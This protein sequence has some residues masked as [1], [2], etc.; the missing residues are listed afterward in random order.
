MGV[1]M[2]GQSNTLEEAIKR[3]EG[4]LYYLSKLSDKWLDMA[5]AAERGGDVDGARKCEKKMNR[6]DDLQEGM[7]DVLGTLGYYWRRTTDEN[8]SDMFSIYKRGE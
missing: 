8:G 5:E 2:M 6:C 1:V 3:I 4:R 7:L